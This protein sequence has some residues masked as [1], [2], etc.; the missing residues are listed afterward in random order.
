MPSFGR[1]SMSVLDKAEPLLQVL[2][3]EAIVVIDFSVIESHRSIERQQ[4]LFADGKTHI[5]GVTQLSKHNY[6]PA[7][8]V[9]LMPYPDVVDEV[10]VWEDT[11]ESRFRFHMLAG[12]VLGIAY[13]KGI[14]IRW[15]G[16][17]D[18]DFTNSD[19]K[20]HDLPHFELI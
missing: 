5:N 7:K 19:Q 17:W 10:S 20:F 3:H 1:Q 6:L 14:K 15:G 9:D 2:C 4:E 16:D 18:R 8:A 12:I 11:P 13:M